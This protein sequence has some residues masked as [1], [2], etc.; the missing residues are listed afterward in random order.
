ME[1]RLLFYLIADDAGRAAV[2]ETN[3]MPA[4][5]SPSLAYALRVLDD[6]AEMGAERAADRIAG[7]FPK[8]SRT[9]GSAVAGW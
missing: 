6:D 3:K 1:K 8:E 9:A 7:T 2:R 4:S 5:H